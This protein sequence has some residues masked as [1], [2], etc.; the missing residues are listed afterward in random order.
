MLMLPTVLIR[1]IITT[2]LQI[3]RNTKNTR[4]ST[5]NDN[6]NSTKNTHHHTS[7]ESAQFK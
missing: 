1:F 4:S 2:L 7:N 6:T 3:M 5:A